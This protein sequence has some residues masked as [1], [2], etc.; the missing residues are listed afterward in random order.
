MRPCMEVPFAVRGVEYGGPKPL[1]CAPL[2]AR[3]SAQLM[4]QAAVARDLAADI[5]EWRADYYPDPAP[6]ALLDSLRGLRSLLADVPLIF[7]LRKREEGGAQEISRETRRACLEAAADSGMADFVDVE[8]DNEDSLLEPLI[9]LC[10]DRG[11]RVILSFHDFAGTPSDKLLLEK[12]KL[13]KWRGADVAKIAVMPGTADDVLRLL[14]VTMEARKAL[15][16][17]AL[18]TMSMGRLGVLTRVAGFLFGS[19]MAYA[20]AQEESAPGQIPLAEAR[21]LAQ[22]LLRHA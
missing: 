19:D 2:V 6:A 11:V 9:R 10:R 15:P 20:V 3:D 8:L 7:T 21:A 5:V 12:I 13:M 1:F 14:N 4:A 17:L 16:D 18:C 22:G